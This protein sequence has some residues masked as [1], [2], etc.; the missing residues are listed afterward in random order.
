MEHGELI[1]VPAIVI[2][3]VGVLLIVTILGLLYWCHVAFCRRQRRRA[4]QNIQSTRNITTQ[5]QQQQQQQQLLEQQQQQTPEL[6]VSS[7]PPHPNA[8]QQLPHP[9]AV[10]QLP[11]PNAPH[12]RIKAWSCNHQYNDPPQYSI[13]N[14]TNQSNDESMELFGKSKTRNALNSTLVI[15]ERLLILFGQVS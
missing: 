7:P 14:K 12:R 4:H 11:H 3:I 10:Q 8:L 6:S 9:G 5:Q 15:D 2:T 1:N 13:L